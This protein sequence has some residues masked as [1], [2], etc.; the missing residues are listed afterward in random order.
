MR[1]QQIL[2]L[3]LIFIA[4]QAFA[5]DH[6]ITVKGDQSVM[7]HNQM[8]SGD[9][10]FH[11][12]V[13]QI[14]AMNVKTKAGNFTRL[15]IPGFHSSHEVGAPELPTMN[16]LINVPFGSRGSV[17][18]DQVNTRTIKMADYGIE[19]RVFPAQPSLSKSADLNNIEFHFD[20]AAYNSSVV[21]AAAQ[22]VQLVEMGTMRAMQ[23]AR[24]QVAP[25]EYLPA[26]GEL[27]ITESI[28]FRVVFDG[29]DEKTANDL[30]A[31][32]YSPFFTHLYDQIAGNEDLD[33]NFQDDYPDRVADKVTM[34]IVTPPSFASQL[35]EFVEWK[36]ERGFEVITAVTGTPEVG[37]TTS[38]IQSY[39]HGLYNSATIENP[40]PSFVIF[41]GD[42]AQMPTFTLSG[43]ATDRPY[44]A[45]D[46]DLVPDMFY[47][48]FSATNPSELQAILDKTMMYDQYTMPD[49]SYLDEVVMIAGVDSGFA[50]SHGN[51]QINYGT[52]HYFNEAHG[53]TSHT[54]LYPA[55]NG[56][57]V[58]GQVV[59][60]A[61][62]GVGFI[63]YTAHGS[64]TSW[65]DPQ[66]TQSNINSLGNE[67][68]Y[69]LAIGNCCLT[70]T[71][72]YGECFAETWL[73]AENKGAIGYIGG[74]N[75]TYWDEDYWWGVGFH[76]S[77][78]INGSA[79]PVESTGVGAY[80]GLFH[81]HGE[82]ADQHYIT[83]DAIIFAGNLAVMEAGSSRITY[84]WNIYNLMGDPSLSTYLGVPSA[85][86]VTLP[87]T[88]F[89]S[90]TTI[91]VQADAGSYVG[92]TQGGVLV[93]SGTVGASGSLDVEL[94]ETLTPGTPLRAVIMA[95]S[96]VPHKVD[97]PVSIPAQ[98]SVTPET[99]PANESTGITVTV[100]ENDGVTPKPNVDIWVE[101]AFGD[102][103]P[104]MATDSNG[105][106]VFSLSIP[107]GCEL[108]MHGRQQGDDFDLF[109]RTLTVTGVDLVNPDLTVTTEHG[110][111]DVFALNLQSTL[112][113]TTDSEFA[114]IMAVLPDGT[115]LDEDS[116]SLNIVPEEGGTIT[117]YLLALGANIYSE[118]FEVLTTGSLRGS[119]N[120]MASYDNSGV[121]V[122]ANP[123]G[124]SVI[125][126]TDGS[127]HLMGLDAG[128]YTITAEKSGYAP[129]EKEISIGEGQH[130]SGLN[131]AMARVY[132]LEAC[133]APALAIPDNNSTGVSTIISIDQD[134][135]ITSIK[136]DLNLTHTYI[137]DLE[138]K[139]ISPA[140]TTIMLHDNSGGSSDNIIGTYPDDLTPVQSLDGLLGENMNGD[141]TLTVSDHA[142]YDTGTINEWCLHLGYPDDLSGVDENGLPSVLALNGNYPNPFNP[143]TTISFDLP[144]STK[145]DLE[146]F[147][148][149]G[150]KVQ[151]LVSET[152]IGGQHNVVW[153]GTDNSGRQVS[154]GTY[155]YRLQADGKSLTNKMLLLK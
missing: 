65:S 101:W 29:Q 89:S 110:L 43:D 98:I 91:A 63:N 120:L 121:V 105:E 99:F 54:Y 20:Q 117:A 76:S 83:N 77:S 14:E 128:T 143:M 12:E 25:V 131:L 13:G 111:I 73:R 139:L 87:G 57:S 30:Y 18:I 153:N 66:F 78:Q 107:Y 55:S 46:G 149:R 42:V 114:S 23:M 144:R 51:G 53:I 27:V 3:L 94:D 141:W 1:F 61:S 50:P 15:I 82:S 133:D 32:T 52:E 118:T 125:T 142:G 31:A 69:L 74:S 137:G 130:L 28:D 26:T 148:L 103:M 100:L 147:D 109:T 80:D 38:S 129:A 152:M 36:T 90:A 56:G 59:G 127:F 64:Q 123:G 11:V 108:T 24:L 151:T 85:N 116:L 72:D 8:R 58:P 84:Y 102:L 88:I 41:V 135:E 122:T 7:Q 92:L 47:G 113:G 119:V 112:T 35:S 132:V 140:G 136:L 75:S 60:H 22:P 49:P 48:R 9:M 86:N 62:N 138:V 106:V 104:P 68:K 40:A 70:S 33:K 21:K 155:F 124:A 39:L 2:A 154:S 134:S 17:V 146:V 19:N 93:G 44:C 16:R 81:E 67:G 126:E 34:V 97:I 145:V 150:R 5:A 95:Q 79:Y 37:T 71:Y 96:K 6:T 45:V 4:S 10:T 115:E